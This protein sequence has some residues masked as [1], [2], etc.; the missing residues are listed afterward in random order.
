MNTP[1]PKREEIPLPTALAPMGAEAI[2]ALWK[3]RRDFYAQA[4]LYEDIRIRV[5]RALSWM[6]AAE[7]RGQNERDTQLL[8]WWAAAGSLFARW[9]AVLHAPL[10]IREATDSF[11]RQA[12]EWDRD[13]LLRALLPTLRDRAAPMWTDPYLAA[14]LGMYAASDAENAVPTDPTSFLA[15]SL[16]RS[17]LTAQ[18]LTL[19]AA[20]YGGAQNRIAVDRSA[21]LLQQLLPALLQV[22]IDHGYVDDWGPLCSPPRE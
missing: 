15:G 20:T 11:A 9:S 19:G 5:H 8:E 16:W 18:Q 14:A 1:L 10:P 12:I 17:G 22:I 21:W 6:A 2:R 13:G 4:H 3:Q 7:S